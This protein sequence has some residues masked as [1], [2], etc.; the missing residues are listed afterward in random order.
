M[1]LDLGCPSMSIW[2]AC[3][4]CANRSSTVNLK[5]H[6]SP[7]SITPNPR[8]IAKS[9]PFSSVFPLRHKP[10]PKTNKGYLTSKLAKK[11]DNMFWIEERNVAIGTFPNRIACCQSHFR[12]RIVRLSCVHPKPLWSTNLNPIGGRTAIRSVCWDFDTNTKMYEVL[13]NKLGK[14]IYISRF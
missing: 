10:L 2:Q 4:S 11:L 3:L 5:Q 14:K 1:N 6:H 12:K 7:G 9:C 13:Y 8:S